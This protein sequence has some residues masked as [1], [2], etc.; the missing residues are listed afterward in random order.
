MKDLSYDKIEKIMEKNISSLQESR[1]F[2]ERQIIKSAAINDFD[3]IVKYKPK[4]DCVDLQ[5]KAL[6]DSLYSLYV[7]ACN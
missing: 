4:L 6:K 5:I 2:F 3:T 7:H 1:D